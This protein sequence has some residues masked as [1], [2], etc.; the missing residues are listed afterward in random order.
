MAVVLFGTGIRNISSGLAFNTNERPMPFH[1]VSHI[2]LAPT[3][4]AVVDLDGLVRTADF[5]RA[6][7]H[8]L[9][10]DHSTEFGPISV[11]C[12]KDLMFLLD[13]ERRNA[14]N[15][16]V[17]EDQNIHKVLVNLLKTSTVLN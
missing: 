12:R 13:S 7:Q 11:G 2:V 9:Q 15:D 6:A 17:R 14:L 5:L 8:I 1:F 10:H 3:D 4:I 16:V